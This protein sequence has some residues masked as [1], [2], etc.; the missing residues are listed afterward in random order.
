MCRAVAD[1]EIVTEHLI[2]GGMY[3]R[4]IRVAKGVVFT[5]VLIK[6]PTTVVVHGH[7][8]IDG[9]GVVEG[10]GVLAGSAF[11]KQAYMTLSDVEMTMIFPTQATT[12]EEAEQEFT[13]ELDQLMTRNESNGR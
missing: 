13:D 2:H 6:I 1:V 5:S 3:A 11:R 10:Y 7:L 12:V 8:A 9:V 4:T